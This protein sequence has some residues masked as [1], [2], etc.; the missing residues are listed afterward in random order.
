MQ[1]NLVDRASITKPH[2]L[3]W[4]ALHPWSV[5]NNK[6]TLGFESFRDYI[7]LKTGTRIY[8]NSVAEHN[9]LY[10]SPS[11][12]S[13]R[14]LPSILGSA[15]LF[16]PCLRRRICSTALSVV[17]ICRSTGIRI[18]VGTVANIHQFNY[19]QRRVRS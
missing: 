16:L 19:Q 12:V 17:M 5:H 14:V 4:K 8:Y 2:E 3:T 6:P 1:V 11:C 18:V 7:L 15:L 13:T 9:L 10:T